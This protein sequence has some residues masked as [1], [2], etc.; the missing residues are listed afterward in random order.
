M[1]FG[2]WGGGVDA[3]EYEIMACSEDGR[4]G[5]IVAFLEIFVDL[6]LHLLQVGLD[7]G[8]VI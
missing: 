6:F 1:V 7:A 3:G 8:N 5:F 4:N 2:F